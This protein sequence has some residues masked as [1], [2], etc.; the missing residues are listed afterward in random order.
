M[1]EGAAKKERRGKKLEESNAFFAVVLIVSYYPSPSATTAPL[2]SFYS[3]A[4]DTSFDYVRVP[5]RLSQASLLN[6]NKLF[7][8]RIIIFCPEL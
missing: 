1:A 8:I 5:K 3:P 4:L 7:A 2:F 6:I